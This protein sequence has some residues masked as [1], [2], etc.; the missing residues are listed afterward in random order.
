VITVIILVAAVVASFFVPM[1]AFLAPFRKYMIFVATC[2]A[3]YFAGQT[4]GIVL[5]DAA[6]KAKAEVVKKKTDE[7]V[8]SSPLGDPKWNDPNNSPDN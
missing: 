2:I 5:A 8:K 4:R 7:T 1:L 3:L 6:C